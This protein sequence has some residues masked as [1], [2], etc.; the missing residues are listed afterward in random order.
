MALTYTEIE[1]QKNTRIWLFFAVVVLFYFLIAIL[2]A[3]VTK[4]FFSIEF[5]EIG[6]SH[7]LSWQQ[8]LNVLL[9]ALFAA[10][11]HIVYSIHHVSSFVTKN[12]QAIPLDPTD[13]YHQR[14]QRII[15]EVNVA[16]GSKYRMTP[17]VI[18][19]IEMNAFAMSDNRGALLGITEGLLSKLNR[20]QL[21]AVV[22]HEMGHIVSGD[23]YQT[24]VGCALF[25]IYAAMLST[26]E[27]GFKEGRL[28]GSGRGGGGVVLFLLL[29][30][31]LLTVMQFFYNLVRLFVS[32]DKELRADAIAVR[33][34]RDPVSLSE[35][36]SIISRG[37]RSLGSIDRSLES[38]FI[39]NPIEEDVDESEGF[40][41]DLLSTHPPIR[42]RMALLAQMA[43][44]DVQIIQERVMAQEKLKEHTREVPQDTEE[45]RWLLLDREK[46]WQGP[47]TL[48]QMMVLGWVTP[49]TWIKALDEEAVKSAK[50]EPLF[51]VYFDGYL[52]KQNVSSFVCPHCQQPLTEE[53]YEGTVGYRCIFCQGIFLEE[54]KTGRI[55]IRKEI[56]FNERTQKLA[57]LL[58]KETLKKKH[59][60]G[61]KNP[62]FYLKCPKCRR[63]MMRN[64]Y[65][66]AYLVEV[67][68][69]IFCDGVWFDK[70]ELEVVQ[71]LIENA[72]TVKQGGIP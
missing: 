42:K 11:C 70:D 59:A 16:T 10:L 37:W 54:E 27:K 21:Q 9:F 24:T 2:L 35:A 62:P 6:V 56:G 60:Q 50:E 18:P 45:R 43:H 1:Q 31:V 47:F 7:F 13:T 53:A 71:Y 32:R 48:L 14:F 49:D 36:L 67:D 39:V 52:Q 28:R 23:S 55:I 68:R 57:E 12:L 20:Q 4:V 26:L 69:C 40:W 58:K 41:A 44:T 63:E 38:L 17:V 15:D 46:G 30:Y 34:T 51:K 8:L 3:S 22:A 29:I 64:F 33:L 72:T 19:T 25:G 65:T 61:K 5:R 66:L